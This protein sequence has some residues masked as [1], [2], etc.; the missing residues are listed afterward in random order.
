MLFK[1]LLSACFMV[2]AIW[3]WMLK[4]KLDARGW[5]KM[6]FFSRS[7][8]WG[9]GW[10][11][12]LF[13]FA[14]DGRSEVNAW[15]AGVVWLSMSLFSNV[16]RVIFSRIRNGI[17]GGSTGAVRDVT[18]DAS[19]L[20]KLA[21]PFDSAKFI[22]VRK[23]IFIGLD[24]Q[25]KPIF[26][27]HAV[28]QKNHIE[29]LG[30]S[31][32][33]KSSLAGVLLS[34]LATAGESVIIF[35]PKG[36][37]NLPGALALAGR[38][39]GYPVRV[40]DLRPSADFPQV[41]PFAGCRADQVEELLQV[42]LELGKTGSG[43]VD[44]YRG[45]DREATGFI[46]SALSDSKT[47]M[48]EIIARASEDERVTEQENLWRELRQVARVKA[49]HTSD[50]LDLAEALNR[51]GVLYIIGST[52]RLEVVAAQKLILQR[53]L[54]ILDERRDQSRPVALFLDELKYL[55][56]PAALRAA[57]TV[58]DRNA[59]LIF[60][61][62][63]LGDLSDCPGLD[64]NAVK[65]AIWG[66]SGIKICY[67]ML[68]SMTAKELETIAGQVS[69]TS[70]S[71][72][73]NDSGESVSRQQ[74]KSAYMPAHVFTHL[75]KPTNGE[76]SVG[77]VFGLGTAFYLSTRF[78]ESGP[79]PE[80]VR[81][82]EPEPELE[83]EPDKQPTKPWLDGSDHDDFDPLDAILGTQK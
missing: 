51:P 23:G 65:G 59:H 62:Q 7:V 79:A 2:A 30:E 42:A 45:K 31:G 77:V 32:V 27:N 14:F 47:D 41:N 48:L 1:I 66:N 49:F 54:Q 37:R 67:K 39:Y 81:A 74:V 53:I 11:A 72:S 78:L 64:P 18:D 70:I 21:K 80:P 38:R 71:H 57:G 28:I 82:V 9:A 60:A 43:A 35:D 73:K 46:A 75:P 15:E 12:L 8:A 68:D 22:D 52:T 40:L 58:R 24:G 61:H 13:L 44:F 10:A 29:I 69:A 33:G 16:C 17:A 50:G 3:L 36:D 26:L 5:G 6:S 55:L 83:T 4:E 63:S 34:Q 76:A 20:Q 25:R 19:Y 56:S